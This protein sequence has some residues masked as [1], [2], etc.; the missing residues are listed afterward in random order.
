MIWSFISVKS[1]IRLRNYSMTNDQ[2][3]CV[4][5]LWVLLYISFVF[6]SDPIK[7]ATPFAMNVNIWANQWSLH[8]TANGKGSSSER[9]ELNRIEFHLIIGLEIIIYMFD[10][11]K[12]DI[13]LPIIKLKLWKCRIHCANMCTLFAWGANTRTVRTD[14]RI[15]LHFT[16]LVCNVYWKDYTHCRSEMKSSA[17]C[18]IAFD[19]M[20]MKR[21]W[22]K[23]TRA[24]C[25]PSS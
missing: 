4:Y 6:R 23:H 13:H 12:C 5:S 11:R 20:K 2:N 10:C 9:L 16:R 24:K 1:H 25:T 3:V 8:S 14:S 22:K 7:F 15:C 19:W 21:W 17:I 18:I